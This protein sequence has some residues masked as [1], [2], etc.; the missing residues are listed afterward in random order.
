MVT[1]WFQHSLFLIF[2]HV[3]MIHINS[4]FCFLLPFPPYPPYLTWKMEDKCLSIHHGV[5]S[6]RKLFQNIDFFFE[7]KKRADD[8]SNNKTAVK[9]MQHVYIPTISDPLNW[10][11]YLHYHFAFENIK[12]QRGLGF[13]GS[14]L[15]LELVFLLLIDKKLTREVV[16]KYFTKNVGFAGQ[17]RN[18]CWHWSSSLRRCSSKG[19]KSK[20]IDARM[21]LVLKIVQ[22]L[23]QIG[24][25]LPVGN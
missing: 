25:R 4:F 7:F 9:S 22:R 20:G 1:F 6:T 10:P 11:V 14:S 2:N 3:Y 8:W 18:E 17:I 16:R 13:R 23:T 24:P 19:N 15:S 21:S 5:F 12:I